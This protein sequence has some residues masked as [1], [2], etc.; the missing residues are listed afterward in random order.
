MAQ[1]KYC[2]SCGIHVDPF[3]M[4]A[5]G[6]EVARCP[7]CGL[8]I[9]DVQE[10][11]FNI[12]EKVIVAEDSAVLRNKIAEILEQ[13][14]IAEWVTKCADGSEFLKAFVQSEVQNKHVNLAIIDVNMPTINGV[15]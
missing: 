2:P 15:T 8:T 7:D 5:G 6:E 4:F 9:S 3:I 10:P 11:S 12:L 13:R 14:R 1:K